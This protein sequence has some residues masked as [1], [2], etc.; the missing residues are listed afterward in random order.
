MLNST[1]ETKQKN[2]NSETGL[3]NWFNAEIET[4]KKSSLLLLP[5][6]RGRASE[7]SQLPSFYNV[8]SI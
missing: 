3:V 4:A 1:N 2:T 5:W 7:V 8:T 6:H